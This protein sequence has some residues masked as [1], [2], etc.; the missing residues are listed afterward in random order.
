MN[1]EQYAWTAMYIEVE[2]W[3]MDVGEVWAVNVEEV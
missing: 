2:I 1:I 3:V